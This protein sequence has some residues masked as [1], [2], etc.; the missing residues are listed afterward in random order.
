MQDQACRS[1]CDS[2]SAGTIIPEP[3]FSFLGSAHGSA[4]KTIG[5]M[6]VS[7]VPSNGFQSVAERFYDSRDGVVLIWTALA[8]NAGRTWEWVRPSDRA[9]PLLAS[10]FARLRRALGLGLCVADGFGEHLAQFR[11]CLRRLARGGFL[12][13]GHGQY[14]GMPEEKVNPG[15]ADGGCAPCGDAGGRSIGRARAKSRSIRRTWP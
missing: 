9:G 6:I 7:E 13:L 11:L 8:A 15:A 5:D 3:T 12:P 2:S 1:D 14:V 4:L 10:I